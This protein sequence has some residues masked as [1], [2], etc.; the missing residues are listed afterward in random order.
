MS[1]KL[2]VGV[3]MAVCT[4]VTYAGQ[5]ARGLVFT[6]TPQVVGRNLGE[7]NPRRLH[8][9]LPIFTEG[10]LLDLRF[11]KNRVHRVSIT[12]L[13]TLVDSGMASSAKS[14]QILLRVVPGLAPKCLV[15]HL[16]IRHRAATLASPTVST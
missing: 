14:D 4:I 10:S 1:L 5:L 7:T 12:K 16:K 3:S 13:R 8:V 11:A 6:L 2:I 9:Q 15:V